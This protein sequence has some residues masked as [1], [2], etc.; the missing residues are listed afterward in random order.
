MKIIISKSQALPGNING[1]T[2]G[3]G[4]L[5]NLVDVLKKFET[6]THIPVV[7][8]SVKIT[9]IDFINTLSE[10]VPNSD[11]SKQLH[12]RIDVVNDCKAFESWVK[13][14]IIEREGSKLAG[15]QMTEEAMFQMIQLPSGL[16]LE[17]I[18]GLRNL[19]SFRAE[20]PKEQIFWDY[21]SIDKGK[22]IIQPEAEAA[23]NERLTVYANAAQ[24]KFIHAANDLLR[25]LSELE[26]TFHA[27]GIVLKGSSLYGNT[28]K[29]NSEYLNHIH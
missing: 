22:V 12:F 27:P 7:N 9:A 5:S 16:I 25:Q 6:E 17:M 10:V 13:K 8:F 23:I 1:L 4:I 26:N 15:I 14:K 3:K 18:E 19:D 24:T 29:F 11:R 20:L 21:L 2:T 28:Y